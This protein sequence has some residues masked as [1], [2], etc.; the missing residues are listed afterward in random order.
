MFDV[1]SHFGFG[2]D[3]G[4]VRE[5]KYHEWVQ[6][7]LDFFFAATLLHQCHKFWPLAP[8]LA[9][10]MPTSLR[11]AKDDH[12]EASLG[13]VRHRM[14]MDVD[15][16]DFMYHFMRQAEKEDLPPDVI[17][18]QASVVILAGSETSAVGLTSAT[19]QILTHPEV[20]QRLC[21]EIRTL[22][23]TVAD[24]NLQDTL[25]KLPYLDAVLWE[26]LR[27][28]A[29]LANGFTRVVPAEQKDFMACGH[30]IPPNVSIAH[31]HVKMAKMTD[32]IIMQTTVTI[33]HYACNT[34]TRNFTDPLVY[35]PER[36]LGAAKYA[37][38][39]REVVQPFSVGP[40]NC[41]GKKYVPLIPLA[42]FLGKVVVL[43][44]LT[45]SSL[46]QLRS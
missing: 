9:H 26:A 4:C 11:K 28:H 16:P 17:E 20:Y 44:I 32:G 2:E 27:I 14:Q 42:S 37:N 38:D 23:A 7:V 1:L 18:A 46:S 6:F 5:G 33:N 35:A 15:K 8:I 31:P 22:F 10:L 45:L 34:S 3:M 29:P 36:W 19:F 12:G 13:R 43:H 30:H 39:Q 21:K 40:R 41:P 25:S 24:I